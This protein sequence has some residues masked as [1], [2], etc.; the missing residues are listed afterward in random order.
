MDELTENTQMMYMGILSEKYGE[1]YS[2]I[3]IQLFW[4]IFEDG[5]ISFEELD[6]LIVNK[7]IV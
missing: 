6:N 3:I 4:A 1:Y 2:G 7:L 5:L